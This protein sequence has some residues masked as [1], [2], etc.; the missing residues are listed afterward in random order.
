MRTAKPA[1]AWEKVAYSLMPP[2]KPYGQMETWEQWR[3]AIKKD[4]GRL[5]GGSYAFAQD[6]EGNL[7]FIERDP[8]GDDCLYL[9]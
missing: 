9:K 3:E 2:L 8:F 6:E 1:P 7:F 4:Y 5:P